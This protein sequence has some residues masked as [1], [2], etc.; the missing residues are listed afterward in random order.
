MCPDREGDHLYAHFYDRHT[1][2]RP[3]TDACGQPTV[4]EPVVSADAWPDCVALR[5]DSVTGRQYGPIEGDWIPAPPV[6]AAAHPPPHLARRDPRAPPPAPPGGECALP[7]STEGWWRRRR[8]PAR[9][10]TGKAR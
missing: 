5:W 9:G 7:A 4:S 1:K 2:P 6:G 3:G 8:R 10:I